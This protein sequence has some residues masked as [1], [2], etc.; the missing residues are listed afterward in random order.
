MVCP[1]FAYR[2]FQAPSYANITENQSP[3]LRLLSHINSHQR[4]EGVEVTTAVKLLGTNDFSGW[5]DVTH[6]QKLPL[7]L[8]HIWENSKVFSPDFVATADEANRLYIG[9]RDVNGKHICYQFVFCDY[10]VPGANL[11]I[12]FAPEEL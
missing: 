12:R 9:V 5:T 6:A 1:L 8:T 10:P 4:K 2:W 7:E 3:V 11:S